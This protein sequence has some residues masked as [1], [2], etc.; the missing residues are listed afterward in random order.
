MEP[1]GAQARMSSGYSGVSGDHF[2]RPFPPDG[3]AGRALA[4]VASR[5]QARS[6][7]G[8]AAQAVAGRILRSRG[9]LRALP[10]CSRNL[11]AM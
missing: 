3:L 10:K 7:L 11:I 5:A 8:S 4:E 2:A 1:A 9:P 6:V